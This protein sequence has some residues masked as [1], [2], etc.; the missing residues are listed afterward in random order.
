MVLSRITDALVSSA[1]LIEA[2]ARLA[3]HHVV[4]VGSAGLAVFGLV[5]IAVLGL[6]A[7]AAGLTWMLAHVIGWPAALATAGA[8]TA[9]VSALAAFGLYRAVR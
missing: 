4:R 5:L 2:E 8:A 9:L 7:M 6:G 3:R 1:D